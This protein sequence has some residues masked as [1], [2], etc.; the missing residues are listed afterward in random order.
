[1][2][3][4]LFFNLSAADKTMKTLR[5]PRFFEDENEYDDEND[6]T[7]NAPSSASDLHVV[8]SCGIAQEDWG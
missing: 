4:R 5:R 6:M 1:V 3:L 2:G 7:S 8:V